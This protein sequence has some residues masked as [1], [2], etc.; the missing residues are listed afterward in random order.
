MFDQRAL[1]SFHI[2]QPR[3]AEHLFSRV[4]F[5]VLAVRSQEPKRDR[6]YLAT[7]PQSPPTLIAHLMA[8]KP[9]S[10]SSCSSGF[11]PIDC[12]KRRS[13][14]MIFMGKELKGHAFSSPVS[15]QS[16]CPT[17]YLEIRWKSTNQ[18]SPALG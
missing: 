1:M 16:C 11:H 13:W 4:N 5:P 2:Y 3:R 6:S 8:S 15:A 9:P 17:I 14:Q 12:S 7:P 10:S 18:F